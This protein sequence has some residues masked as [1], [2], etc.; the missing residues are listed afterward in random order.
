MFFL[1]GDP[2]CKTVVKCWMCYQRCL[3]EKKCVELRVVCFH[4]YISK[5]K[6]PYIFK[7]SRRQVTPVNHRKRQFFT[8]YSTLL[9]FALRAY[10]ISWYP[11]R[12]KVFLQRQRCYID[13]RPRL[14][15]KGKLLQILLNF[16]E[17]FFKTLSP[18]HINCDIDCLITLRVDCTI[19]KFV[20]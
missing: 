16:F 15:E 4:L 7:A 19:C 3:Q 18:G 9:S 13:K 20:E 6:I 5:N 10:L 17:A 2:R 12:A 14:F 11:Y 8:V 1:C